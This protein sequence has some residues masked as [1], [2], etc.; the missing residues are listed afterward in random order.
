M[1]FLALATDYDGTLAHDGV[2]SLET[3][4]AL[5]HLRA[6]GR[7]LML[8][9]GRE[10]PDLLHVFPRIDLF[11]RVVAENGALIYHPGTREQQPLA[12]PPPELFVATLRQRGVRPLSVGRVIVATSLPNQAIVL[13]TIGDLGLELQVILNKG[14]IMVLPLRIDKAVGLGAAL[15]ELGLSRQNVI[16]IGDAENDEPFMR[17]CACSVAVANA[18][19]IVKQRADMVT[20]ASHGAGVVELINRIVGD[21]L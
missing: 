7:K 14:A 11:D 19:P 6:T 2:V 9:T 8:V 17:L 20:T 13:K 1:R 15:G 18:L 12:D 3:V 10:L 16:G 5:E 4:A 21:D